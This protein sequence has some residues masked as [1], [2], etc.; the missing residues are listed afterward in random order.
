VPIKSIEQQALQ[1]LQRVRSGWVKERTARINQLRG[2]LREL[3]LIAPVGAQ[4]FVHQV[5]TLLEQHRREIPPLLWPSLER[6]YQAIRALEQHIAEAEKTLAQ[7]AAEQPVIQRLRTIPGIGLVTACA[8]LGAIPDIQQ[9][10]NGRHLAAWLGLVPSEH[11]SGQRRRLGA[12]SKVGSP[13]L[14]CLLTH[15]ARSLLRAAHRPG[16]AEHDRLKAWALTIEQR[17]GHNKATLAV[18]NKLARIVFA[19]WASETPYR[20]QLQAT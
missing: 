8:L 16:A 12:I 15:G 3:G 6:L 18:A 7:T 13:D 1:A 4:A 14:R 19:V 20:P 10:K 17:R 2:L 11:S 5:P 9:F